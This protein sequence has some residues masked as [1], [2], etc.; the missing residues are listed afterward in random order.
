M[1]WDHTRPYAFIGLFSTSSGHEFSIYGSCNNGY[2][3]KW[4][5]N[6]VAS[7]KIKLDNRTNRLELTPKG[8][9]YAGPSVG[10]GV[11]QDLS[12][13]QGEATAL[14]SRGWPMAVAVIHF[15]GHCS[16]RRLRRGRWQDHPKFSTRHRRRSGNWDSGKRCSVLRSPACWIAYEQDLI[17]NSSNPYNARYPKVRLT[18]ELLRWFFLTAPELKEWRDGLFG[19]MAVGS[20]N[21]L[22]ICVRAALNFAA[23]QDPRIKNQQAYGRLALP[24]YQ[25]LM[26]LITSCYRTT[27]FANSSLPLMLM[28]YQFGLLVDTKANTG[29]TVLTTDAIAGR[30]SAN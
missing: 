23:R 3:S 27:R 6:F 21:R 24:I 4:H 1:R 29:G 14:G 13:R 25:I 8:K 22:S 10:R 26:L 12:P 18:K 28:D 2:T 17:T 19:T 15:P 20:I 16:G 5:A 11:R 9:P 7:S 30:G